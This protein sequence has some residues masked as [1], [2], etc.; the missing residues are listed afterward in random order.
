MTQAQAKATN[1]PESNTLSIAAES[2]KSSARL[3]AELGMSSICSNAATARAF[4]RVFGEMA[5]TEA[6]EVLKDKVASVK[7]NDLTG[8]EATLT[9]QASALNTIFTELAN[10]AST[11]MG[12]YLQATET[13][14]RLA[15]KAQAQCRATIE[16]LAEIKNPR[17]V[18]FVKQ[19][20]I[21]QGPQQVNNGGSPPSRAEETENLQNRLLEARNDECLDTG[22]AGTTGRGDPALETVGAVNRTKDAGRQG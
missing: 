22:A 14:L 12:Q 9:A 7:A 2:S 17:P 15:F 18:A 10:R 3:M 19:A 11:N 20:N 8:L 13:Y 16:T 5:I 4:S 21:A 6:V 1:K